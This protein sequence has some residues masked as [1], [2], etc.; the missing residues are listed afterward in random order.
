MPRPADQILLYHGSYCE[1]SRPE[2]SKCAKYKDFGRGF[3]LTTSREQACSFAKISTYRAIDSGIAPAEQDYGIVSLFDFAGAYGLQVHSFP[4]ADA[5]W[6]RC[7]VGHRKRGAFPDI[8][9]S[10]QDF[11]IVSGKIANDHTNATIIA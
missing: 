2:L 11:D 1:V 10:L 9:R 3:Y 7:V 4:T 6:L 5:E 8:V